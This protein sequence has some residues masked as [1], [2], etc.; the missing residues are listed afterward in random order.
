MFAESNVRALQEDDTK[1]SKADENT[2]IDHE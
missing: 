1:K 2:Q